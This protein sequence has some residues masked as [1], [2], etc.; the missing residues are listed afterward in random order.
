MSLLSTEGYCYPG[1]EAE[2]LITDNNSSDNSIDY[3]AAEIS[4]L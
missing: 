4:F 3:L 2:V 1:I